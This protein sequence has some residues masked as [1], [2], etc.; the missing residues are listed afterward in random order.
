VHS[1]APTQVTTTVP[2][3]MVVPLCAGD[4]SEDGTVSAG[5]VQ[6]IA[7]QWNQLA[8]S[9]YDLDEDGFVTVV[10]VMRVARAWGTCP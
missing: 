2:I 4:F 6:T 1:R 7:D 5:D 9:P 8:P 10:D 3:S